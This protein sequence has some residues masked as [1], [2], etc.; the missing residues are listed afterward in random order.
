MIS[1]YAG[2]NKNYAD[3]FRMQEVFLNHCRRKR[4][5]VSVQGKGESANGLIIGF[6]PES[7]ILEKNNTQMLFY[8]SQIYSIRPEHSVHCI[9]AGSGWSDTDSG[10]LPGCLAPYQAK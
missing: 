10:T 6:D 7:I 9:F 1:N 8:K 3:S 5:P 2:K 4:I